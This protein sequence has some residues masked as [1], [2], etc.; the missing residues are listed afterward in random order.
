MLIEKVK[1]M[2]AFER[3]VY[4]ITEREHIRL[5]KEQGFP[6]P[7]TQDEIL[8][9]YRF[10]NVRRMDDKVSKWLLRNWYSPMKKVYQPMNSLMTCAIA[11]HL[12]KIETLERIK[13]VHPVSLWEL[14]RDLRQ[15]AAAGTLFGSAY[16]ITGCLGGGD[17]I[18]QVCNITLK[19]LLDEPPR[20]DTD[21]IENT[22]AE[23]ERYLGIG[24]FMAGQIVADL[25]WALTGTWKDKMTW[26]AI[27]PGSRRGM[28]RLLGKHPDDGMSQSKFLPELR[29][30]MT[31]LRSELP[32]D[33]L[34]KME[35]ID[36]QN[37][38]CEFDKYSRTLLGEGRPKKLYPGKA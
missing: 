8:S 25:R 5:Q 23:L 1:S 6:K 30:L 37:C 11:R 33:L 7:W 9:S 28:N 34:G 14:E 19:N 36:Y 17:K 3:M 12:N 26:A 27:G 32:R 35:A 2:S 29:K 22:V 10:C 16:V 20:I 18:Y 15:I 24:S 4:W 31:L 13:L 21:S 38:L